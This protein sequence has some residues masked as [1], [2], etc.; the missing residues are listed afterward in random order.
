MFNPGRPQLE[1]CMKFVPS[2]LDHTECW[3]SIGAVKMPGLLD[4]PKYDQ[5]MLWQKIGV[6]PV[7]VVQEWCGPKMLTMQ[8]RH[9]LKAGGGGSLDT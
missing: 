2:S 5:H 4:R 3:S 9:T 8:K 1:E 7:G 6:V